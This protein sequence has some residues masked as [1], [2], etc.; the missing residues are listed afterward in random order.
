MY[1]AHSVHPFPT[2][3]GPLCVQTVE[4]VFEFM[5][6]LP[7]GENA[8]HDAK[9]YHD[10]SASL[11]NGVPMKCSQKEMIDCAEAML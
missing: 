5:M 11:S 8:N 2:L 3:T 10:A 1:I 6:K 4:N 9:L 7:S